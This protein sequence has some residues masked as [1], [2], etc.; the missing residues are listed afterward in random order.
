[1]RDLIDDARDNFTFAVQNM[2]LSPEANAHLERSLLDCA[3]HISLFMLEIALYERI[4]IGKDSKPLD[5]R[6]IDMIEEGR[7]DH[8]IKNKTTIFF[9]NQIKELERL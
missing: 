1:M 5:V 4:I 8:I 7:W 9:L 6:E 2:D 3:V